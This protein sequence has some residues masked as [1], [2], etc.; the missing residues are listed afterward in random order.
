MNDMSSTFLPAID[1]DRAGPPAPA[2]RVRRFVFAGLILSTIAGLTAILAAALSADGLTVFEIGMVVVFAFNLPW[3]ALGFWNAAIGFLLLMRG[4]RALEGVL[5]LV[6][7]D[8]PPRPPTSRCAIV[9]PI[10]NEDADDAFRNLRTTVASLDATAKGDAFDIFVLSDTRIAEVAAREE[11]L[12]AAWRVEDPV[13][14]R[15]HYRRRPDNA[16]FKAGN[17]RDFC[18]RW[19]AGYDFMI[20]LDCDSV[21]TGAALVRL[22]RLME[23]NPG[24]GIL[25]TLVVGLPAESPFARIFQFGMRLGMRSYTLGSM[26]WQGDAGPYWG[27]NAI[28]RV[29]PFTQH[30]RLPRLAGAPPLG[31]PVLSHD[32]VE[33][34]LM[35]RA[36]YAVRVLPLE[37]GSYEANPPTLPAFLKRDLR[38]CQGNMQYTRLLAMPGLHLLGRVQLFLAILMY[39][40]APCWFALVGLGLAQAVAVALIGG[41]P[42]W[43]VGAPATVLGL[44]PGT[45]L[46]L[47]FA[48]VMTMTLAPKLAATAHVLMSGRQRR[49][50]GG[51]G[52]VLA[53]AVLE[54][55]FTVLLS[56]VVSAA[57]T[58]FVV[59]LAFG[60]RV[61]WSGQ[62]R[63]ATSLSA[64]DALRVLW[65]QTVIGA[66]IAAALAWA[67]PG[68][69]W[70]AAPMWATLI[71][72]TVFATASASPSLGRVLAGWR[73]CATPE[74]RAPTAE[75]LQVSPWLTVPR[76]MA[77]RRV[78]GEPAATADAVSVASP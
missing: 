47:V 76:P 11:A 57:Q 49:A 78:V 62:A 33:A 5:P 69:L 54:L 29:R 4:R 66:V 19:G 23:D 2:M 9:M 68:A 36:G 74:E 26:W 12:F 55:V 20:V 21:M 48:A 28:V 38:W 58:V 75:V 17:L 14:E 41:V 35:R 50:F 7:L 42:T 13:P 67:A 77:E 39:T 10:Y 40:G 43:A 56:P 1:Q 18:E 31:G 16:D 60:R 37:D 44:A 61:D 45:V 65:P 6:G 8:D 22:A 52:P 53:G 70:I 63:S 32:Q 30:C 34:A 51:T 46:W 15:L 59:G 71:G 27:H 72:A 64:A 73:L 24:L 25:Q 3:I